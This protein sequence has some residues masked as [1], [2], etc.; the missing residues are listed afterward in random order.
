M[1]HPQHAA[2][3]CGTWVVTPGLAT[4]HCKGKKGPSEGTHIP[5]Q[6]WQE[7]VCA[8][9]PHCSPN[10]RNPDLLKRPLRAAA[11]I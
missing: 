6:N 11:Q 9:L 8:T 10:A 4:A 3:I 1:H 7:G 5:G 2:S